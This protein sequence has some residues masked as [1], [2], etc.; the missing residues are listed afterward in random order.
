MA[1][2]SGESGLVTHLARIDSDKSTQQQGMGH[3]LVHA[4]HIPVANAVPT[5]D[6]PGCLKKSPRHKPQ[7]LH[8]ERSG[9]LETGNAWR[10][11]LW[12]RFGSREEAHKRCLNNTEIRRALTAQ[13]EPRKKGLCTSDGCPKKASYFGPR[14][15]VRAR[16]LHRDQSEA[17][18]TCQVVYI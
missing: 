11:P 7:R 10:C 8:G 6:F 18:W 4:Y 12:H 17:P 16:P 2:R 1:G 15:W 3:V 14:A 9:H 5:P 13:S